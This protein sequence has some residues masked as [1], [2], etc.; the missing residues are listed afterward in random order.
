MP[1]DGRPKLPLLLADEERSE[2]LRLGA[3]GRVNR[4]VAFRARIVLAC[5]EG[6]TNRDVARRLRSE[7]HTVGKWRKRFIEQRVA[8]LYD[9]PRVG[10]PRKIGDDEVDA[11]VIK[12]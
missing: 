3:R 10:A 2:L 8:G 9:E 11:I 6:G 1:R 4:N 5:A 7:E 12:T